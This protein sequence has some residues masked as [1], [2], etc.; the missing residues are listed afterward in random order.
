MFRLPQRPACNRTF[1][2]ATGIDCTPTCRMT[3]QPKA[4]CYSGRLFR[5]RAALATL[6]RSMECTQRLLTAGH[7]RG[8][9]RSP[10]YKG[11]E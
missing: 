5:G 7:R 2:W 6:P 4:P 9:L 8:L 1:A 11:Y 10:R 3:S